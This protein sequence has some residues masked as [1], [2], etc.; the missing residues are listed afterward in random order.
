[1]NGFCCAYN[2]LNYLLTIRHGTAE[3]S[4]ECLRSSHESRLSVGGKRPKSNS[5]GKKLHQNRGQGT[6]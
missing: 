5:R 1:M 6:F 4:A 2:D 3:G